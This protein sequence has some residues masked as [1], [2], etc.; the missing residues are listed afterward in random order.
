MADDKLLSHSCACRIYTLV[1][2]SSIT[3][4]KSITATGVYGSVLF[5]ASS[6][7][8]RDIEI[9]AEDILCG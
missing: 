5:I 8:L 2:T 7:G 9:V 3:R 4:S 1:S 6:N